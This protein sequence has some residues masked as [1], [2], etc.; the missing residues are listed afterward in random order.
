MRRTALLHCTGNAV[1]WNDKGTIM[2]RS[3]LRGTAVAAL[4]IGSA[5]HAVPLQVL[6][7]AG[8]LVTVDSASP[9]TAASTVA[10]TGIGAGQTIKGVD[11]RPAN[12]R[13]LYGISNTGQL[14]AI[15]GRTG[16]STAVGTPV[17]A[18]ATAAGV[19]VGFDFNP[20]VDRIRFVTT[21]G[22]DLRLNPINGTLAATDGA[23]AYAGIDA[24]A[25][26]VPFVAGSAYTNSSPVGATTTLYN[27]DTRN[28]TAAARLV[29]QGNANVSPNTGILFTVGSTGVTTTGAVGFDIG[30]GNAAYATLTN[31]T[32]GV[33]SLYTVN[34]A[35]G[36]ATL[37]G[38]LA[39]NTTYSALAVELASFQSMGITANQQAVGAVLD[40]FTGIPNDGTLAL[41]AG[42]D[43]FAGQA[44]TQAA[45]LQALT[46]A[47][48]SDLPYLS[49]N[50]V[51]SQEQTVLRYARN[52]R[53]EATLP[54]GT[55]TTLD[56]GGR[57]GVW[58]NGGSRFGKTDPATDRYRT[59]FDEY[60]FM[61]GVDYRIMPKIAAGVYG[62]Y[63]NTNASLTVAD[64]GKGDL[65]SWF[66]GAYGTA[67]VGPVY[68]DAWGSYT[69]L[70]WRLYR[71]LQFG[72]YVGSTYA[73]TDGRVWAAGAATG[74]SFDVG[75][76]EIE[77]YAAIRF[78]DVRIDAFNETT[79]A[80]FALAVGDIKDK[81][82]RGNVGARVGAK[83]EVDQA[84][85]RPQLRAGWYNEFWNGRRQI[86]A[87]FQQP[88][89][90]SGFGFQPNNFS[91][92]YWNFGGTLDIA[93]KGP[94]SAYGDFDYQG[95]KERQFYTMSVGVRYKF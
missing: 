30:Q 34:L 7:G 14:Y 16:A 91:K 78:A 57:V 32:T 52:L 12:P 87:A 40:G 2:A 1:C 62:G 80:A 72:S 44:S 75:P 83:F 17:A 73:R 47:V 21:G 36:T 95:D 25:G 13:L 59:Q 66:A 41:F 82:L 79:G 49:L 94:I 33:T 22:T 89:I 26:Q 65:E 46:P 27:I 60:H 85:V 55:A 20:T 29:T 63:S 71:T 23:V 58:L 56:S 84:I 76:L 10:I 90:T 69:D 18:A 74:L 61:G 53:G 11:Y 68:I 5:A 81:S 51:E 8:Q 54:D 28:G 43:S 31:P 6:N 3:I 39:G 9:G 67:A 70:D 93:G 45:L 4:A 42:I 19:G 86:N 50:A 38:A 15:N 37:V 92:Q 64:R 48:Y 88:G 24:N 77:P 35:T